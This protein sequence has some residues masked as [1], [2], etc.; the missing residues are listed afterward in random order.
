MRTPGLPFCSPLLIHSGRTSLYRYLRVR[1]VSRGEAFVGKKTSLS[2]I[3][4]QP[5]LC[6]AALADK[7]SLIRTTI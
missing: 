2:H 4:S 6:D 1:R 5:G 3:L 7:S